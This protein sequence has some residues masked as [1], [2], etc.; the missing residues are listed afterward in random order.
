MEW[1]ILNMIRLNLAALV[2]GAFEV[3][4][5]SWVAVRQA[6]VQGFLPNIAYFVAKSPGLQKIECFS[7]AGSSKYKTDLLSSA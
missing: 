2:R 3:F 4:E 7:M 1:L 6:G 5:S